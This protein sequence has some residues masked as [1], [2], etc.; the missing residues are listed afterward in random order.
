MKAL[1][2]LLLL[3]PPVLA[4]SITNLPGLAIYK[5]RVEATGK[6]ATSDG[7]LEFV[8]VEPEGRDYESL[9]TLDC[10][11]SALKFALLLIGCEAGETNGQ[12]LRIE[13]E[14]QGNRRPVEDL[15]IERRTKKSPGPLPWILT[16]SYFNRDPFT[17]QEVFRSDDEAAHIALWWQPAILINLTKDFGNPYRGADQGFEA[18]PKLFP[19]KGTPIK[20]IFRKRE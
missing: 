8:A 7:I 15:L 17:G 13:A 6:V 1:T 20:L 11:P 3:A 18:N 9:F 12:P 16:G 14:W 19:A 5:D 2:L 10:R 4:A